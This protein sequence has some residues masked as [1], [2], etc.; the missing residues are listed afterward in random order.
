[1]LSAMLIALLLAVSVYSFSKNQPELENI[2]VPAEMTITSLRGGSSEPADNTA[3]EIEKQIIIAKETTAPTYQY[4]TTTQE[5][6]DDIA[7][8]HAKTQGVDKIVKETEE[9]TVEGSDEK[10]IENDYYAINLEKTHRIKAGATVVNKE[11][12]LTLAYENKAIDYTLFYAPNKKDFGIGT[13][14]TLAKW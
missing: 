2:T 1:M 10:V 5:A 3:K 14:I 12:Y 8:E 9:K 7:K 6:A 11:A 4:Y 13:S